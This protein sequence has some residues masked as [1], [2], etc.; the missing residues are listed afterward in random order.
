MLSQEVRNKEIV[1]KSE[2]FPI[3]LKDRKHLF[4]NGSR[5]SDMYKEIASAVK[6]PKK[7]VF[8]E[9]KREN[10]N[11][12]SNYACVF[13]GESGKLIAIPCYINEE[14]TLLTV[15]DIE[16]DFSNPNWFVNGYNDIARSR[17]MDMVPLILKKE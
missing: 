17:G 5:L 15:K 10:E 14:I 4:P 6:D 2:H 12:Q 1:V 16:K 13:I 11:I 8:L 9:D 7:G 3:R